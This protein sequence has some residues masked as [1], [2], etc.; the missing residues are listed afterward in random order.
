MCPGCTR[1][2]GA[3]AC[4]SARASSTPT[5]GSSPITPRPEACRLA[6]RRLDRLQDRLPGNE[7]VRFVPFDPR[8]PQATLAGDALL[9]IHQPNHAIEEARSRTDDVDRAA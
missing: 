5:A 9:S 3:T 8:R 4:R 2:D 1:S 6:L 7:V